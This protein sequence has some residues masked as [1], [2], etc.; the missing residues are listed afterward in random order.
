[1]N[2]CILRIQNV[3]DVKA[4]VSEIDIKV[5]KKIKIAIRSISLKVNLL[6]IYD[7]K[8]QLFGSYKRKL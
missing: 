5:Q 1:M 6:F 4:A 3:E 7:A 2:F 8:F